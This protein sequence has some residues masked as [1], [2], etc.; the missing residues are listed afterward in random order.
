MFEKFFRV[1]D[2]E[3]YTQGTVLGLA[4]AKNLVAMHGGQ[5]KAESQVG[6]GTTIRFSIPRA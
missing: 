4:I 6:K 2:S 5:I 1:A 3:G